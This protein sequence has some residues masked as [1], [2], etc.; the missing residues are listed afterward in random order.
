V[1]NHLLGIQVDKQQCT[2]D[3]SATV[4]LQGHNSTQPHSPLSKP[5]VPIFSP[6]S[7]LQASAA[8]NLLDIPSFDASSPPSDLVQVPVEEFLKRITRRKPPRKYGRQRRRVVET[9]SSS[10]A[11]DDEDFSPAPRQLR[12]HRAQTASTD[13][14]PASLS[15]SNLPLDNSGKE[16]SS[17]PRK[18]VKTKAKSFAER[19]FQA[20]VMSHGNPADCLINPDILESGVSSSR[21]PLQFVAETPGLPE[22]KRRTWSLVDP[23]KAIPFRSASFL[24]HTSLQDSEV[25]SF[26]PLTRWRDGD[27]PGSQHKRR[28]IFTPATKT[29]VKPLSCPPLSFIPIQDAEQTYSLRLHS[30]RF[31]YVHFI[32]RTLLM[33]FCF[34]HQDCF[35]RPCNYRRLDWNRRRRHGLLCTLLLPQPWTTRKA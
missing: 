7:N 21:L 5:C 17:R 3:A 12:R 15:P 22:A 25:M 28:K 33:R 31:C 23:R 16:L 11:Q 26:K 27:A 30:N 14:C 1:T 19:L 6:K 34:I 32:R 9:S 35:L 24:S 4:R 18:T 2:P 8:Q 13:Y 20:S 29:S 10:P